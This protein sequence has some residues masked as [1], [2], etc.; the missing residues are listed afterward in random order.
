MPNL[1]QSNYT[2]EMIRGMYGQISRPNAPYDGDRIQIGSA[3]LK[4]GDAFTLTDGKAVALASATATVAIEGVL[5]YEIG[6]INNDDGEIGEY[7]VDQWV[8]YVREG[9]VYALASGA[10]TKGASLN[11]DPAT[12][13]WSAAAAVPEQLKVLTS[14]D[15]VADGA[16]ME[17]IVGARL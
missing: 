4:S 16:V 5:S 1:I 11:F 12:H 13:S 7:E 6:L 14:A 17:V 3:G 10:V 2:S 15:A 8:P 9:Y